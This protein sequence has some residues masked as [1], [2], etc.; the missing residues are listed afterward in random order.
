M[1]RDTSEKQS[2]QIKPHHQKLQNS[3]SHLVNL[4]LHNAPSVGSSAEAKGEK[5]PPPHHLIGIPVHRSNNR[6]STAIEKHE[7]LQ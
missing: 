7:K 6:S 5:R 2:L 4:L 1:T 3:K